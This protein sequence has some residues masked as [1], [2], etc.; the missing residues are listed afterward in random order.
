MPHTFNSYI[1]PSVLLSS[2]DQGDVLAKAHAME[3]V[4]NKREECIK[5]KETG[6]QK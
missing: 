6:L 3:A 2:E 1:A 4:E 5:G